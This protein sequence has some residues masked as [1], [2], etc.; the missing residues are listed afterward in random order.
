L[1]SERER[2]LKKKCPSSKTTWIN[3]D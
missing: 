1:P 2:D 3:Y